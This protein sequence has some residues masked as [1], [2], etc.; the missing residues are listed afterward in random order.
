MDEWSNENMVIT[1]IVLDGP[2]VTG[3][4]F[5]AVIKAIDE[6]R[7]PFVAFRSGGD[8]KEVLSKIAADTESGRLIFKEETPWKP[9]K[10]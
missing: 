4:G 10:A 7:N 8:V 1:K 2:E 3:G 9:T 6:A 5:R